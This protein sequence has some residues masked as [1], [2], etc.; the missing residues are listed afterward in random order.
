VRGGSLGNN[1]PEADLLRI[2]GLGI[3]FSLLGGDL[4]AVKAASLR[5]LP[6][7]VTA[8]VGDYQWAHFV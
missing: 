4:Q 7:C 3:A 2:E 5:V 8:L 6:G 1:G